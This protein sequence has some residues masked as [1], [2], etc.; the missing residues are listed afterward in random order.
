MKYISER[1]TN[2]REFEGLIESAR[3]LS[4]VLGTAI[5]DKNWERAQ[6]LNDL[7]DLRLHEICL[8]QF[9]IEQREV[10][11]RSSLPLG[12]SNSWKQ[13][14]Q[15]NERIRERRK[16]LGISQYELAKRTHSMSQ[17]KIAKIETGT[18]RISID[19]LVKIAEALETSAEYLFQT[20]EERRR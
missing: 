13:E 19:D 2:L 4:V 20:E 17:S 1:I 16:R 12:E 18:V 15:M 3:N 8:Y 6:E 7:F 5:K 14:M 9:E 10:N 11:F